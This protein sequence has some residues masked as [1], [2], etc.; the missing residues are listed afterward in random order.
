MIKYTYGFDRRDRMELYGV[1]NVVLHYRE[2]KKLSQMQVCEGICNEM[3][4]SRIETGEREFD[5][6]LSETLLER[7]GKTTNRFEFVLNDEDY[8]YYILRENVIKAIDSGD[9]GSAKRYISD[10]RKAMSDTHVLHEQFVLYYEALIMKFEN[11]SKKEIVNCLYKALH[12]TRSDFKDKTIRMRLYSAIEIRIIYE[13]SIYEDY[14]YEL[15]SSV[16]RF[17]DE[18]YDEEE[19]GKVLIPFLYNLGIKYEQDKNWYELEKISDKAIRL[20][21]SGRSYLYMVEF[22]YMKVMA[23]QQ[24]YRNTAHWDEKRIELIQRCNEIYY[25]SMAIEHDEMMKKAEDF[26]KE[27]LGCQITM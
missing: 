2:K 21:Q 19:K 25:M 11:K 17:V 13:L 15:L 20:L 27:Q 14:S 12:L 26:C 7:L 22:D 5:S 6:L 1:G 3:T 18:V 9:L 23:E 10:Y 8:Y 24:L 16:F 4:M